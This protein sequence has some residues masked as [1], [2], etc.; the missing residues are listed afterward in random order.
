MR[1]AGRLGLVRPSRG[2]A[3]KVLQSVGALSAWASLVGFGTFGTFS[4]GPPSGPI[5]IRHDPAVLHLR[6]TD[7]GQ[8]L[9]LSVAGLV[10]GATRT[11]L[12]TLTNDGASE[13]ASIVLS[14]VATT[15]SALDTD[16]LTG[17][18]T[19]VES[20]TVPWTVE[21]LCSGARRMLLA[22]G[23]VIRTEALDDPAS[24]LPGSADHLAVAV[25]LPAAAGDAFQGQRSALALTFTAVPR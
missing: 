9:S 25:T 4:D 12:I 18:R 3:A 2:T 11:R 23:P 14:T 20:C 17:L 13:L 10:P 16:R 15:S 6:A 8:E 24:L 22:S 7:L 19:A 5:G 21:G 1:T